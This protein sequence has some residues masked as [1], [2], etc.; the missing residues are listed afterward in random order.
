MVLLISD[1]DIILEVLTSFILKKSL[2]SLG[3][4]VYMCYLQTCRVFQISLELSSIGHHYN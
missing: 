4:Y 2:G 3:I 1:T